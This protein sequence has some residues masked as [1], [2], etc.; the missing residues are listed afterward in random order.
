MNTTLIKIGTV[1]F[2]GLAMQPEVLIAAT[3]AQERKT[4]TTNH[5]SILKIVRFIA[6]NV[7]QFEQPFLRFRW[8]R[9]THC[10]T[11]THKT[12]TVTLAAHARRGLIMQV[13]PGCKLEGCRKWKNFPF[14]NN[15]TPIFLDDKV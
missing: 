13:T 6:Q 1:I 3:L 12:T 2:I 7:A 5:T 10:D 8:D 14:Q 11:H 9:Q 4:F 15:F